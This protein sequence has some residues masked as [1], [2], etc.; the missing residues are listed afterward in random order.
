MANSDTK[1]NESQMHLDAMLYLL[2]DPILDRFA[3]EV[4]LANDSKLS[5]ILTETVLVFHSLQSVKFDSQ[6]QSVDRLAHSSDYSNRRWQAFPVIA[7]SLL[8]V[9]FLGWQTLNSIRTRHYEIASGTEN[10]SRNQV[11]WAWGELRA[12]ESESQPL[13]DAVDFEFD[14]SLAIHD[15]FAERDVPEWLVM[16]TTDRLEGDIDPKDVKAFIQ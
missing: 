4:R 13:R 5:E 9:G 8:L 1:S 14:N 16:A 3:F 15:S 12:D 11:V 7:A 6:L 2:D 10:A